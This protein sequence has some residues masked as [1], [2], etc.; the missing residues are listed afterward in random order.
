[1]KIVCGVRGF[2]IPA[3]YRTVPDPY[4]SG[5]QSM[6]LRHSTVS[7]RSGTEGLVSSVDF[8]TRRDG[9][10]SGKVRKPIRRFPEGSFPPVTPASHI[11]QLTKNRTY[12][13]LK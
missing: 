2:R 11:R 12:F 3:P 1:M 5:E 4:R 13:G 9:F 6:E 8:K 10:R 7:A